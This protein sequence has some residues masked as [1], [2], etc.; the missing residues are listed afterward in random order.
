MKNLRRKLSGKLTELEL[1]KEE[2][3]KLQKQKEQNLVWI[4]NLC[5]SRDIIQTAAQKTQR[6]LETH[7]TNIVSLALQTIFT[8]PYEFKVKFVS[9]RNS[10]ECDLLLSKNEMDFEP[11][12]SCGFGVA[13]VC[14]F[15]LRVAYWKLQ[16]TSRGTL[17]LDEPFRFCDKTKHVGLAKMLQELSSSL[18]IQFI[19]VTHEQAISN[20]AE[21]LFQI[22]QRNNVS[23]IKDQ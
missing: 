23:Y 18:G 4:E 8:D 19:I 10:T 22:S 16:N 3:Q 11:L 9:R 21:S 7:I 13:D 5:I 20:A 14:S 2:F 15:A 6:H 1:K 12:E 17:I